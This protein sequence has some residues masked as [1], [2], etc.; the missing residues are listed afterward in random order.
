MID[1]GGARKNS[2]KVRAAL[3]SRNPKLGAAFD[4][5]LKLEE[6]HRAIMIEVEAMRA[7]RNAASQQIGKAMAAKD[8]TTADKL[9][10][11]V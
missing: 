2:A 5:L 4:E 1:L 8:T 7:Q 10:A 11:E 3:A 9:K 6:S